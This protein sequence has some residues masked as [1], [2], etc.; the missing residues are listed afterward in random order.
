MWGRNQAFLSDTVDQI[1]YNINSLKKSSKSKT[2]QA[3]TNSVSL[4]SSP[5]NF[6]LSAPRILNNL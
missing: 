5:L 6:V 2:L 4:Y 1:M 3:C